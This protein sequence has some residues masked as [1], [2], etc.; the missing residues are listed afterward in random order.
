MKLTTCIC[1]QQ[2][3]QGEQLW[4]LWTWAIADH[5]V[6]KSM[7]VNPAPAC[8]AHAWTKPDRFRMRLWARI[9][10]TPLCEDVNECLDSKKCV[11]GTCINTIGGYFC[12][13]DE[14]W[15]GVHCDKEAEL[16]WFVLFSVVMQVILCSFCLISAVLFLTYSIKTKCEFLAKPSPNPKHKVYAPSGSQLDETPR[17]R[18]IL[19]PQAG[20]NNPRYI[21]RSVGSL[22]GNAKPDQNTY[23]P[24]A[25]RTD[26]ERPESELYENA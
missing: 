12:G 10:R 3:T 18:D 23:T 1:S 26:Q 5:T 21:N 2:L 9:W 11:H 19:E 17:L 25:K 15:S 4:T 8:K 16:P 7:S 22:D 6:R 24:P 20:L 14:N 13:C